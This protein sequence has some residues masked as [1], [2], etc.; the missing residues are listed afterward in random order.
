MSSLEFDV[1]YSA[2]EYRSIFLDTVG[3]E[4][5]GKN[6][7]S[8]LLLKAFATVVFAYKSRKVGTCAFRID[9]AGVR[10]SSRLGEMMI[11]WSDVER[12]A[13]YSQ[14]YLV[15]L[16]GGGGLPLPY[17]CMGAG[18]RATFERVCEHARPGALESAP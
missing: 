13:R 4:G 1:K 11:P 18:E 3:R 14:C 9:E 17:R 12:V 16:Q 6:P 10:R 2:A 5:Y 7:F 15:L 8:R